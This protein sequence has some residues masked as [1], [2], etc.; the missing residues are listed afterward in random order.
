V[1]SAVLIN[2]LEASFNFILL[3]GV[4]MPSV[5]RANNYVTNMN[6]FFFGCVQVSD[7]DKAVVYY[8]L[9]SIYL[10]CNFFSFK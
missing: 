6:N 7:K 9:I 3:G 2:P 1:F 4:S 8:F 10:A 5:F